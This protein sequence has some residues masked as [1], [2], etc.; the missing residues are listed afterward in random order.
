[1]PFYSLLSS[2]EAGDEDD[3]DDENDTELSQ[4]LQYFETL[5]DI[6]FTTETTRDRDFDDSEAEVEYNPTFKLMNPENNFPGRVMLRSP[7][8][9]FMEKIKANQ[10]AK[11]TTQHHVTTP[12]ASKIIS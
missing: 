5:S 6:D 9:L 7:S 2:E 10:E 3:E 1:M 12:L 11:H 8:P 4:G